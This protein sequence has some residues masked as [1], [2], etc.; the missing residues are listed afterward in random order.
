[1][2][3]PALALSEIKLAGKR[4]SGEIDDGYQKVA[5]DGAEAAK[6]RL[7]RTILVVEPDAQMQ[8]VFRQS[9]KKAGYRVL[10]A[11][12]AD[13]AVDRIID[14]IKLADGAVFNAQ[15][16]GKDAVR[17]FNRLGLDNN[18]QKL[19]TI[20]LLDEKQASWIEDANTSANRVVK[21][22]P[23]KMKDLRE[24]LADLVPQPRG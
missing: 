3:L 16:I 15:K 21:V 18:G 14:D 22:L 8:N 23:L 2:A 12:N 17:A 4:L 10:L 19:P 7:R 20:L 1:M 9:L 6:A 13:Q 5:A 11:G 24:T